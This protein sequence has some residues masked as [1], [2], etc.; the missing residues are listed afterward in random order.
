MTH[1]VAWE[2]TNGPIPKGISVC[3]RCDNP[4][5]CNPQ[6]LFLGTQSDNNLDM[7]EKLRHWN[8]KKTHCV[9]GHEYTPENTLPNGN[10]GRK[11]K[12]CWGAKGI[13]R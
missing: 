10:R 11:C 6:H 8:Q 3:H 9:R 4:P 1:R 7:V 12:A 5:C 2:V 13:M